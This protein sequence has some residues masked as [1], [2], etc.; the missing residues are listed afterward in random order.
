MGRYTGEDYSSESLRQVT[1]KHLITIN[2]QQQQKDD[3]TVSS[4]L[5]DDDDC[6]NYVIMTG[7]G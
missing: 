4:R 6:D 5:T 3:R 7:G 2:L 1:K